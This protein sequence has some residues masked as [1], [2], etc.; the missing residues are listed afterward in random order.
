MKS[1][2]FWDIT[3][4][5]PLKDNRRFGGIYRL[6]FQAYL[7]LK[8]R[9]YFP[10]ECPLSFNGIHG[11]ICHKILL[12]ITTA[13]RPSNPANYIMLVTFF[14]SNFLTPSF[15]QIN[16]NIILPF[17]FVNDISLTCYVCSEFSTHAHRS[18]EARRIMAL[19]TE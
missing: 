5:R 14:F 1:T 4:C 13:V 7:A 6:H 8:W 17:T 16:F 15:F 3:P 18:T 12:F 10:Q 2:I 11:V 9:Q 19:I